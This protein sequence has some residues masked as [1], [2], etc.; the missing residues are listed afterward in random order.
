MGYFV[1]DCGDSLRFAHSF[2]EHDL[3]LRWIEKNVRA[4]FNWA[5]FQL[6]R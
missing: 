3:L 5:N 6:Y 4:I 2:P 1:N